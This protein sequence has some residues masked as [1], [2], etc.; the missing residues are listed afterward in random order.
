MAFALGFAGG[1]ADEVVVEPPPPPVVAPISGGPLWVP[2]RR[3]IR[4]EGRATLR[5]KVTVVAWGSEGGQRR[6]HTIAASLRTRGNGGTRSS[7]RISGDLLTRH[8]HATTT[9]RTDVLTHVGDPREDDQIILLAVAALLSC[10][11][12]AR[13]PTHHGSTR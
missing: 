7:T 11:S 13:T 8:G 10:P 5:L 9:S 6:R 4:R 3:S 2:D 12:E 1:F